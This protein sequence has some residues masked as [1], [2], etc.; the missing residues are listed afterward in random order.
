MEHE[1]LV[2]TVTQ[3]MGIYTPEGLREPPA[4]Q[5]LFPCQPCFT[6]KT[7]ETQGIG[8]LVPNHSAT[9]PAR[10]VIFIIT[11]RRRFIIVV[12]LYRGRDWGNR[13]VE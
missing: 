13:E 4:S 8:E 1:T 3:L 11:P 10:P 12:P 7:T 6:S 5:P 9:H 2:T